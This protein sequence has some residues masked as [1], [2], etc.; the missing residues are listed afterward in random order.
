[1]KR[2]AIRRFPES[3]IVGV[4][5]RRGTGADALRSVIGKALGEEWVNGGKVHALTCVDIGEEERGI[6]SLAREL[7]VPLFVSS[8]EEIAV[9][10]GFCMDGHE[11]LQ[12]NNGSTLC[13]RLVMA[14]CVKAGWKC[15][16]LIP[17]YREEGV[18]VAA[19]V[20]WGLHGRDVHENVCY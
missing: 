19:A 15:R 1:M 8:C 16:L 3:I 11:K 13:E 6:C 20:F 2:E 10:T 5:C 4:C 14:T 18:A 7:A 9:Q 17:Q 12:Y